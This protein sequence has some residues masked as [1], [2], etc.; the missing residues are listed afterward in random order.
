MRN[1]IERVARAHGAIVVVMIALLAASARRAA[2]APNLLNNP[3]FDS[4]TSGWQGPWVP[5]DAA[6]N[7]HSGSVRI[8]VHPGFGSG[9]FQCAPVTAGMPYVAGG[10]VWIDSGFGAA[11]F[12][13]VSVAFYTTTDCTGS[14]LSFGA[15]GYSK[16]VGAWTDLALTAVAPAQARSANIFL[17]ADHQAVSPGDLLVFFDRAVLRTGACAPGPTRLCLNQG[18]FRVEATWTTPD[19]KTGPGMAVPFAGDSGS[20]WFFDAATME[21][22]VKV[23]RTPAAW[24]T[25][26]GSSPPA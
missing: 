9:V 18:R 24:I 13:E 19:Q 26:T 21:M 7:P 22:D 12:A 6:G 8:L 23:L 1:G 11:D 17:S 16:A 4:N 10:S 3:D 25:T 5:F 20:F 14:T 2:A 15:P